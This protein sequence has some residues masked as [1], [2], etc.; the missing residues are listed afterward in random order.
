M[1]TRTIKL[2]MDAYEKL[3]SAKPAGES[4]SAVVRRAVLENELLTGERLRNYLKKGGSG[5]SL[6]DLDAVEEASKHDPIP[7]DS[8][9]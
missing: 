5:V 9:G 4:F 3:R 1:P 6:K 8:R 7:D 2:E